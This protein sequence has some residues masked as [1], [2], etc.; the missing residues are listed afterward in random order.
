MTRKLASLAL[1]LSIF[2]GTSVAHADTFAVH[3]V[4]GTQYSIM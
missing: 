3:G 2:A 1:A 4:W